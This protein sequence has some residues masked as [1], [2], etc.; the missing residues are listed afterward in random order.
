MLSRC[1]VNPNDTLNKMAS[2]I[3][4]PT[5]AKQLNNPKTCASTIEALINE[6]FEVMQSYSDVVVICFSKIYQNIPTKHIA[7]ILMKKLIQRK[8]EFSSLERRVIVEIF[9]KSPPTRNMKESAAIIQNHCCE[10]NSAALFIASIIQPMRFEEKQREFLRE[11]CRTFLQSMPESI[12]TYTENFKTFLSEKIEASGVPIYGETP[13]QEK[14]REIEIEKKFEG[15]LDFNPCNNKLIFIIFTIVMIFLL[16][17]TDK[18]GILHN[19]EFDD[20]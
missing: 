17:F 4:I 14:M 11:V 3:F 10:S 15:F 1:I 6:D 7:I 20:S 18:S 5:I 16:F 9:I 8:F 19:L 12:S 2:Q 13:T